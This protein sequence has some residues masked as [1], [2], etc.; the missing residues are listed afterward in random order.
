MMQHAFRGLV[1]TA[2]LAG[3]LTAANALMPLAKPAA[4][5]DIDPGNAAPF[6]GAWAVTVPTMEVGIPDTVLARCELPVRIEAADATHIFYLGPRD[7][8]ADAAMALRELNG[9]ALWEPIAGGPNFFAF[10]VGH[11]LFYLYDEVP[12][13]DAGWGRPYVYVRCLQ[14]AS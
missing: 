7:Q 10:W 5:P 14:G 1:V 8:E 3:S 2:A 12:P 13:D 4:F 11:D 9:G 6:A